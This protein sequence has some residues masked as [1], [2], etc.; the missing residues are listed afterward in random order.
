MRSDATLLAVPLFSCTAMIFGLEGTLV[1]RRHAQ[2]PRRMPG[3]RS[4]LGSI[5]V[6]RWAVVASSGV[7]RATKTM[8]TAGIPTPLALVAADEWLPQKNPGCASW[9]SAQRSRNTGCGKQ[10][11]C[12][13]VSP[14]PT[15]RRSRM[16][17]RC[18]GPTVCPSTGPSARQT[19]SAARNQKWRA[20]RQVS[21]PRCHS[22]RHCPQTHGPR[23][24]RAATSCQSPPP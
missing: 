19:A 18:F 8:A 5:P 21:G 3:V 13:R 4:F 10:T 2:S 9:D 24:E 6:D 17:Y 14:P 1:E 7:E 22:S 23:R 20:K 11:G 15:L 12:F 16:V